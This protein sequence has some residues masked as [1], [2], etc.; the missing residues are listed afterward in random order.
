[1]KNYKL[2]DKTPYHA[3]G[4]GAIA[5]ATMGAHDG[6]T[7]GNALATAVIGA[8]VGLIGGGIA[9]YKD[10]K[11]QRTAHFHDAAAVARHER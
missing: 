11:R 10:A 7:P 9:A 3:A 5:G 8:G 2:V 4:M 6:A 1:M